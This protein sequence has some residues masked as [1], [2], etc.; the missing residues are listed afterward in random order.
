MP[1][2]L[3]NSVCFSTDLKISNSE[4]LNVL[5][6]ASDSGGSECSNQN[7]SIINGIHAS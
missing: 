7:P 6:V 1:G 3:S 2:M 5:K 4:A